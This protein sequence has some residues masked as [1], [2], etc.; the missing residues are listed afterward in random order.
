MTPINFVYWLQGFL[1]VSN[2]QTIDETQLQ[3]IRNHLILVQQNQN[4]VTSGFAQVVKTDGI[5]DC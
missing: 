5:P 4:I 2:P 3:E 1:E